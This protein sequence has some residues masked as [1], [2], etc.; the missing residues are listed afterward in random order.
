MEL[1]MC[2]K[3]TFFILL[4]L[5]IIA[6]NPLISMS[7]ELPD[8]SKLCSIKT[9]E[10]FTSDLAVRPVN[11]EAKKIRILALDGG[12]IKSIL[13]LRLLADI[14]K[15]TG[16]PISK[17][18]DMIA[19][20]SSGGV[21]ALYLTMPDQNN[22]S[23][24]K[25]SVLELTKIFKDDTGEVFKKSS[26]N[27]LEPFGLY[28]FFRPAYG[29]NNMRKV[30]NRRFKDDKMGS[31]TSKTF[32]LSQD[33]QTSEP[34]IFKSYEGATKNSS[35]VDAAMATS[36]APF[37]FSPVKYKCEMQKNKTLADG[38]LVAKNPSMFAYLEAKR[39]YPNAEIVLVSIG[40]GIID[41]QA[42]ESERMK[43]WGFIDYIKPM[44]TLMLDGSC[45]EVDN[46]LKTL[47]PDKD[48]KQQYFRFQIAL[49]PV[50]D[51]FNNRIDDVSFQN[52]D[53]LERIAGR[54][55]KESQSEVNKLIPVLMDKN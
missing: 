5:I 10:K 12:G 16:E 50:K 22:P 15:K 47:I 21:V 26:L 30:F 4:S 35:V 51:G 52:W 24:S 41:K 45:I 34:F 29:N 18:F 43:N 48:G 27:K 54:F 53:N 13:T 23:K 19:G 25:Y 2:L 9:A 33:M 28:R 17:S 55:V 20:V 49:D 14:E 42:N 1:H 44:L 32:V 31:L 36:V 39:L 46:Y 38:G 11:T 7:A 37:Y 3:K 6:S 40:T 8:N